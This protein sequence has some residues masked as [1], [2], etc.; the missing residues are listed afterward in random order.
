MERTITIFGIRLILNALGLWVAI[1]LFGTGIPAEQI[2][3]G[4]GGF[5]LAGLIFSV[6]NSL[7]R[8]VAMIISLP[9]L[10]LTM[11]LFTLVINGAMVWLA[12]IITPGFSMSFP[13]S[14]LAGIVLS[15]VNYIVNSALELDYMSNS[16][17]NQERR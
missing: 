16:R 10:L 14:I 17:R 4:I 7:V 5:I 12:L 6:V 13:H 11:G 15:L 8:P 3:A 2:T 1:R 9:A